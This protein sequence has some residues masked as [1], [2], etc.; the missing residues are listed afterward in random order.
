M[1]NIMRTCSIVAGLLLI[2]ASSA[3]SQAPK[4]ADLKAEALKDWTGLKET[5]VKIANEMPED[6]FGFKPTPPQQSYGERVL[7]VA[8]ANVNFLKSL[9]GKATPPAIDAKATSK[10]EIVK[11]MADSFD[12]GTALINEQTPETMLQ[13]VTARFLGESSRARVVSFLGGHAWDIYGQLAV[14]LRLSG[15]VPPASQRP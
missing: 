14:Y 5:M 9:G 10:T 12:F 2:A 13:T 4:T 7:H 15:G 6:K 3:R 1:R 11:A 8:T